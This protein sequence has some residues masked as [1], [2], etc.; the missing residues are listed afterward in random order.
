MNIANHNLIF[1][2]IVFGSYNLLVT[3]STY[4]MTIMAVRIDVDRIIACSKYLSVFF[5]HICFCSL[6]S[7]SKQIVIP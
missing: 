2:Y 6:S 3:L 1:V 7:V 4:M 5:S